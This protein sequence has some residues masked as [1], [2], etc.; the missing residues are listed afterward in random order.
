MRRVWTSSS[1]LLLLVGVLAACAGAFHAPPPLRRQNAMRVMAHEE[2][3]PEPNHRSFLAP[4]GDDD[5]EGLERRL[6]PS[7]AT[8]L[9]LASTVGIASAYLASPVMGTC[10]RVLQAYQ[11]VC[12]VVGSVLVNVGPIPPLLD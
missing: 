5:L 12:N 3:E 9:R 4:P 1:V 10:V 11:H 2:Y 8:L 6:P 7:I